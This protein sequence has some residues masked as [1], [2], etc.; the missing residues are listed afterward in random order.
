MMTSFDTNILVYATIS[1]PLAKTHRARDLLVRGMRTGSCILL[2]QTLAEFSSVAIRKAGIAV[3]EVRTTID[4]WRAVLP[5]QGTEDDD[6]SAALG[7]VKNHRLAFWDALLW[8]AAQ[9]AG[10]RHLLT[11]DLQDGFELAGVRFINPFEAANDRL[12][13][14]IL[15]PG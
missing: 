13:D 11:E 10:V 2:L 1:A 9:R 4:A 8:G 5:V 15:P 6:L 14:E 7:A 12:I 3:D